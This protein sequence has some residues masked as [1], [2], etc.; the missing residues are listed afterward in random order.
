MRRSPSR[1]NCPPRWLLAS[2]V[3][4]TA[5]LSPGL[6][7]ADQITLKSGRVI[8]GR[9]VSEREKSTDDP[10]IIEIGG[11]GRV[12]FPR[13]EIVSVTTA[14]TV[15]EVL[16]TREAA[17][18]PGSADGLARLARW[19]EAEGL[20]RDRDR[21]YWR[22]LEVDPNHRAARE[23]LGFRRLGALWLTEADY[24][25]HLGN[26]EHEGRWISVAEME[27]LQE[28]AADHRELAAAE[29]ALRT[30]SRADREPE[31]AA[32]ALAEFRQLPESQ[33]RYA[34]ARGI[35]ADEARARQFAVR[36][37][38]ELEG[39]RPARSLTQLAVS[40]PR[41][42]VRD[43]ALRVLRDWDDPDTALSFI[44]YLQSQD[45]RERVN[46]SRALNVFPD[47]RAVPALITTTETIW[48]GFG[49][50][51]IMQVV[52]RSYV[53]DYELVS[54]GTGLVVSEVADPIIDVMIE[55]I[56]LDV[57]VR[58]AE[59]ISRIATLE[60]I[61]GQNFGTNFE[62]WAT[63]WKKEQGKGSPS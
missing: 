33:K 53:Q 9:I 43:E 11:G 39:K 3:I 30:A 27:R 21:L 38:G 62:A 28:A 17:L 37:T 47:R 45:D 56:V 41:R 46:A 63:W 24:Q 19:C 57:D 55:G 2:G 42:S 25:H 10:V 36:L 31:A 18:E 48:A 5:A 1:P 34:L 26:V 61:T 50:A 20:Q 49:R 12:S 7:L 8:E 16:S 35:R 44:P 52:Q 60:R 4:L 58:R 14:P 6:A 32:A 23:T 59:A 15:R 29:A 51:Y 13:S 54:G 22:L 40:D